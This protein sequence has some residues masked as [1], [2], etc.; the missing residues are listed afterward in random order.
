MRHC[1]LL[2][3]GHTATVPTSM[4]RVMRKVLWNAELLVTA[5]VIAPKC[6]VYLL[7]LVDIPELWRAPDSPHE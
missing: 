4:A 1:R 7:T 6:I 2:K 5:A 3:G